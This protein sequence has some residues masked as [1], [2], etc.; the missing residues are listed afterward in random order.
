MS[1][2]TSFKDF[3]RG[4]LNKVKSSWNKLRAKLTS[5]ITSK[6]K[7]A[8]PGEEVRIRIPA[9]GSDNLISEA[10][11]GDIE[12]IKGNYNEALLLKMIY[13]TTHPVIQIS[14]KYKKN[15]SA[16]DQKVKQWD[17]ALKKARGGDKAKP[18]IE[19]GTKAMLQ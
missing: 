16:I 3:A 11:S 12:A 17:D 19:Q 5:I 15:K 7:K 18:V 8:D 4:A 13:E 6:L 1:K 2:L 14:D 9:M 10:R